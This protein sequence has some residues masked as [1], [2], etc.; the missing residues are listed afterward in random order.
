MVLKNV[1]GIEMLL[2]DILFIK[3]IRKFGILLWLLVKSLLWIFVK[4]FFV[5]VKFLG[6]I[7]VLMVVLILGLV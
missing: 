1:E 7:I 3:M 5:F 6:K 4:L 2:I